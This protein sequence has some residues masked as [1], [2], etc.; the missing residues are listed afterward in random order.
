MKYTIKAITTLIRMMMLESEPSARQESDD[1]EM[2]GFGADLTLFTDTH[3]SASAKRLQHDAKT[4]FSLANLSA[5]FTAISISLRQF[6]TAVYLFNRVQEACDTDSYK[7]FLVFFYCTFSLVILE[8]AL[9][10]LDIAIKHL[11]GNPPKIN[12]TDSM[13]EFL[14]TNVAIIGTAVTIIDPYQQGIA[15]ENMWAILTTAFTLSCV[16]RISG[17]KGQFFSPATGHL[18]VEAYGKPSLNPDDQQ[19]SYLQRGYHLGLR[20]AHL[21]PPIVILQQSLKNALTFTFNQTNFFYN[22]PFY[23]DFMALTITLLKKSNNL[24]LLKALWSESIPAHTKS[25]IK[26]DAF[27]HAMTNAFLTFNAT[28]FFITLARLNL[29]SKANDANF[30]QDPYQLYGSLIVPALLVT[31]PTFSTALKQHARD[32]GN[33]LINRQKN[34]GFT[35]DNDGPLKL[36]TYLTKIPNAAANL[37]LSLTGVLLPSNAFNSDKETQ[38]LNDLVTRLS[39][40]GQDNRG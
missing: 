35:L 22:N 30:Y 17:I 8:S 25:V 13:T 29:E 2:G 36:E 9:A 26:I 33:Q 14:E 21:L 6:Y 18:P 24:L 1:V 12:S 37:F 39:N 32:I 27:L 34:Q 19:L 10:I 5:C 7:Q 20:I 3:D 23:A 15:T 31:L 4:L 11:N 16:L 40:M 38:D 28:V